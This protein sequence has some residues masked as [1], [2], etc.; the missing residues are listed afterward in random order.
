METNNTTSREERFRKDFDRLLAE[1][2]FG[3]G[4]DTK[5]KKLHTDYINSLLDELLSEVGEDDEREVDLPD[6]MKW[7]TQRVSDLKFGRNEERQR[8]RAIINHKKL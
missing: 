1:C 5:L 2:V 6:D 3:D 8:V 4:D 7:G